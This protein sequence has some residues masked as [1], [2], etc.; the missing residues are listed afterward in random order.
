MLNTITRHADETDLYATPMQT[1]GERI[2]TLRQARGLSQSQLAEKVS[3][4]VGSVSQ[5]ES[6][7]IKNIK[8]P[9]FLKLCTELG[10]TPHYLAFG[11]NQKSPPPALPSGRRQ[12]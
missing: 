4:T 5:W 7:D 10:T 12:G 9:T 6:G 1:M 2:R 11:P 8:I 3:V